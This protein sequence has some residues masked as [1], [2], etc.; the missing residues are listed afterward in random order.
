VNIGVL[1]VSYMKKNV[2]IINGNAITH[3][4]ERTY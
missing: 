4:T 1:T 2:P 3:Q